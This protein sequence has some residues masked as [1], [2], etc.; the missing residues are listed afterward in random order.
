MLALV[1]VPLPSRLR[2][3]RAERSTAYV[4]APE[5]A[6]LHREGNTLWRARDYIGALRTFQAGAAAARDR[7][8]LRAT[9][10]FLNNTGA[11]N[12]QLFRFRDAA[13]AYTEARTLARSQQMRDKLA[14][15]AVNLASLYFQMNQ[16]DAANEAA[17]EGLALPPATPSVRPQLLL[18]L[19]MLQLEQG[20]CG[21]ATAILQQAVEAAAGQENRSGEAQAWNELGNAYV[22]CKQLDAAE[23]ALLESYRIRKLTNDDRLHFSLEALATLRLARHEPLAARQLLD[24]AIELAGPAGPSALW[25]P[26]S[27]RGR[28]NVALGDRRAAYADFVQ[29][30]RSLRNWRSEILPADTFRVSTEVELHQVYS[31]LVDLAAS[32]YRETRDARYAEESFSTAESE[33]AASLRILWAHSDAPKHLPPEYWRTLADLNRAESDQLRGKGNGAELRRIRVTLSEMEAASGLDEPATPDPTDSRNKLLDSVRRSLAPDEA[34]LA[35]HTGD[36]GSWLWGIGRGGFELIALP[37]ETVLRRDVSAFVDALRNKAPAAA[38]LGRQL[39]RELFGG[40]SPSIQAARSWIVAAD[41]PLFEA[42]LAALTEPSSDPAVRRYLIEDHTIRLTPDV[43]ALLRPRAGKWRDVFVG[44][45]DPIYNRADPRIAGGQ[46]EGPRSLLERAERRPSSPPLELPRLPGSEREIEACS[47]IWRRN[48]ETVLLT[49]QTA[50]RRDLEGALEQRPAVL[51]FAGHLLFPA[52]EPSGGTLAL[53]LQ[54]PNGVE[55]LTEEE[56][57][58]MSMAPR[59]V[60]LSG[61][62]SGHGAVLPGTGLLGLTRAWLAAGARAVLATRWPK[63]DQDGA[64][65]FSTFYDLYSQSGARGRGSCGSLLRDAQLGEL[66]AGGARA[67]PSRWGSYFCIERN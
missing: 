44:V 25:R 33:R 35:F 8:D 63:S 26:L 47:R 48:G 17:E 50:T 61:C 39:A 30:V 67:D 28:A 41:G 64:A 32:L 14:A 31:P 55:L 23:R 9:I 52:H 62:S 11:A 3:S 56:T 5:V 7:G 13:K 36:E 4:E 27:A 22:E 18:L 57:L 37:A 54:P 21:R 2:R 53:S 16:L 46:K 10:L 29:S 66:R 49:G 6:R 15:I 42:P 1:L 65:I 24:R 60:V 59:L 12:T 20:N 51:H 19:G 43:S 58:G 40:L 38:D 45:A 34:F